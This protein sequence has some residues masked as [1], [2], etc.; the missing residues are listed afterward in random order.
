[1]LQPDYDGDGDI[2]L[3]IG[4][5]SVPGKY[6]SNPKHKLLENDGNGSYSDVTQAKAADLSQAG[7]VTEAAW[8]DIDGDKIKD[9]IIVGDWEA[10]KIYKNSGESLQRIASNL[11]SLNGAW[12]SLQIADLNNDGKMDLVLGN[13][14][15]NSFY[16]VEENRPVKVF[17]SDFDGNGTIEQIFTRTINGKDVPIHLRRELTKEIA[18]LNKHNLKSTEYATK[19]MEKLFSKKV[20]NSAVVK[21]ISTFKSVIAYNH[22]NNEFQVLDLPPRVQFSSIHA[23]E[24]LDLNKDGILDILLAGN[25]F[26]L[27]PQFGRLDAN[28][29]ITL[30]S[31]KD[32]K[33]SVIEPKIS[34]FFLKGAVRNLHSLKSVQGDQFILAG[35]NNAYPKIFKLQN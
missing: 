24:T 34:G 26:D 32:G 6:G 11:D 35:V 31:N 16:N 25:D 30:L 22:G 17:I 9:L 1:M 27:K 4:S 8:A 12:N 15:T 20:M 13:R 5:R 18:S 23:I 10:P 3:F 33:Y 7:M 2:D 19:S 21:N 29:G 28:Y 14:G